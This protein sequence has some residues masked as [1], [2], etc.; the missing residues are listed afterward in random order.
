MIQILDMAAIQTAT[1]MSMILIA[2]LAMQSA[3]HVMDKMN[4]IAFLVWIM[5]LTCTGLDIDA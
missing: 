5:I 4:I 1:L 3:E 2:E